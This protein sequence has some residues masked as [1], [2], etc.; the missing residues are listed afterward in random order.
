ML[1]GF[2]TSSETLVTY[3]PA[4]NPCLSVP[5]TLCTT[6]RGISHLVA[7]GAALSIRALVS[8]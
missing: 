3:T 8:T 1:H 4:G 5:D 7:R 6:F 2:Y